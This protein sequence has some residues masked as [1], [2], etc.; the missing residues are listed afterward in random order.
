M[1]G[2]GRGGDANPHH[3]LQ[4]AFASGA[5]PASAS[6]GS[7]R[8][9]GTSLVAAPKSCGGGWAGV[10]FS[11]LPGGP[12]WPTTPSSGGGQLCVSGSN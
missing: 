9:A 11:P 12:Y 6:A 3:P 2:S 7:F 8:V 4:V 1:T 10:P 5:V